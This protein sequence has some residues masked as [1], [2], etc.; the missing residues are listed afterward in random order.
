MVCQREIQAEGRFLLFRSSKTSSLLF[1][2][3]AHLLAGLASQA[4]PGAQASLFLSVFGSPTL[5]P[6][7]CLKLHKYSAYLESQ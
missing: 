6:F 5:L 3:T 1:L 4:V 2:P 7:R